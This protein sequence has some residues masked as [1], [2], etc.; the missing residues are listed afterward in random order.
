MN[1]PKLAAKHKMFK[2]RN[3]HF[4]SDVEKKVSPFLTELGPE[5]LIAVTEDGQDDR[6]YISV[7]YWESL[8]EQ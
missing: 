5:R 8:Q 6:T 2:V 3:S 1:G 7:H 4:E